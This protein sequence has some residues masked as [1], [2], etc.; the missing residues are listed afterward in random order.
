MSKR[1]RCRSFRGIEK[2]RPRSFLRLN[3]LWNFASQSQL[4]DECGLRFG[5]NVSS[6]IVRLPSNLSRS[7]I[8]GSS[9][10]SHNRSENRFPKSGNGRDAI[11]SFSCNSDCFC[12]RRYG[13]AWTNHVPFN[14]FYIGTCFLHNLTGFTNRWTLFCGL[15]LP[16]CAV[17]VEKKSRRMEL[18]LFCLARTVECWIARFRDMGF[19]WNIAPRWDVMLF[20]LSVAIITHCYSDN[21]GLHRH[22]FR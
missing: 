19:K 3:S 18:A 20:S 11:K 7:G 21:E 5:R 22:A 4:R 8:I 16:G 12:I 6:C 2:H 10:T 15:L 17:I 1:D 13:L 9:K 14:L